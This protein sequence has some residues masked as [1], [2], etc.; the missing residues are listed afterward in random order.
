MHVREADPVDAS[1]EREGVKRHSLNIEGRYGD[2]LYMA[3]LLEP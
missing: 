1:F 3:K 2:E